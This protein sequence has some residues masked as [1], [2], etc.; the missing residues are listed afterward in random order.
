MGFRFSRRIKILPGVR[1]N[2]GLKGASIS[3]GG[4]G[5]SVTAGSRGVHANVGLPG[6]GL[7]YRTRLDRPVRRQSE[8]QAAPP[9]ALPPSILRVRVEPDGNITLLDENDWLLDDRTAKATRAAYRDQLIQLL[10]GQAAERRRGAAELDVHAGTP[11]PGPLSRVPAFTAPKPVRPVDPRTIDAA[12]PA[13]A[14]ADD[15]WSRYMETL[16]LWRAA[17]AEHEKRHGAE[18]Q[19]GDPAAAFEA[20]LSQLRWPR[21]TLVTVEVAERGR[22]V[23]IDVDLPE[24]ED[25]P[26]STWQ[27]NQ[28]ALRLECKP[29][30]RPA[31]HRLYARHVHSVLFR[32]IGEAFASV[33]VAEEARI[34]GYTQR[35]SSATGTLEDDYILAVR[36]SREAW[37]EIDF[38]RLGTI[39]PM[40]ALARLDRTCAID[41]RG[42]MQPI[43]PTR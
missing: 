24:I 31:L 21:E 4:R 37:A 13:R 22:L 39:D 3:V 2:V 41:S 12:M 33:P 11:P 26:N 16:G 9:A 35:V 14:A 5:A 15:E 1:L 23:L 29:L 42:V 8:R 28:R 34:A 32:L 40:A 20:Q 36:S 25:L 17:K 10:D 30:T 43:S 18:P 38:A 6:T 19:S 7:S 27:V